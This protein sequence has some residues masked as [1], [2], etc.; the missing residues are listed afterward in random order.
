MP[1]TFYHLDAADYP[2]TFPAA[3]DSVPVLI[4]K[5]TFIDGWISVRFSDMILSIQ[6][7]LID[8]KANIER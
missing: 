6:Q 5:H 3:L 7:Y 8:N 2:A 4:D 1:P